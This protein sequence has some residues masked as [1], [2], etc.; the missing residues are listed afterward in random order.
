MDIK[1]WRGGNDDQ[2]ADG[3]KVSRA[4]LEAQHLTTGH[5]PLL[6]HLSPRVY[7]VGQV[8]AGLIAQTLPHEYS[9]EQI[10]A[11]AG[12]A[13]DI[14]DAALYAMQWPNGKPAR[15]R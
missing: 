5:P 13:I 15:N 6:A 8:L 2:P 4:M 3:P 14:T 9:E 10:S 7:L 11:M 12:L 1:T